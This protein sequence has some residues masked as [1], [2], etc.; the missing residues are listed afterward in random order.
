M[1]VEGAIG[2]KAC[3]NNSKRDID[4]V[5]I[6]AHKKTKDFNYIRKIIKEKNIT[7]KEIKSDDFINI[8]NGKSHGGI[9][10]MVKERRYD[11][12]TDGDIF[13]LDGIEDPFNLAYI[14]RTLYAFGI[15]NII[16]PKRDYSNM[17]GQL[18]KSSAGAYE[19]VNIK[20]A[21][22]I[23]KDIKDLKNKGYL[24]YALK[25][26]DD[27]KDIFNTKFADKCVFLLGGE[28][29]GISNSLLEL[30]DEFLYIPYGSDFR[31]SLNAAAAADVVA[32]LLFSQR[33]K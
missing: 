25:R 2:V 33:R 29:R 22:D 30:C 26:G 28:K 31:N 5:Y 20:I 8:T 16:L 32:T 10:A 15:K 7:Y 6:D 4:I 3:I 19:M 13:Y 23:I 14:I 9:V 27:A 24:A 18:I 11:E 12:L 21:E 1:I 17:E